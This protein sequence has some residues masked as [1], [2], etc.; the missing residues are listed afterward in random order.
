VDLTSFSQYATDAAFARRRHSRQ[1]SVTSYGSL[2][3]RD[4]REEE[5]PRLPSRPKIGES[6]SLSTTFTNNSFQDSAWDVPR[7][8]P[9]VQRY[10]TFEGRF[11]NPSVNP[12][13]SLSRAGTTDLATISA[14]RN[15]LRQVVSRPPLDAL[16]DSSEESGS[17]GEY[18][19]SE[20]RSVSPATSHG[21]PTSWTPSA[22][23][24]NPLNGVNRRIP[25]PVNRAKKPPPPPPPIRR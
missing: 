18:S 3:R 7:Q 5:A 9:A 10:S 2:E 4:T 12:P 17:H 13:T 23:A 22:G 1:A 8:R 16:A 11:D 15:N 6:R 19:P 20:G 25:P 21:S 14:T 24:V